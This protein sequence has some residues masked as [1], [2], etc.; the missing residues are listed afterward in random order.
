MLQAIQETRDADLASHRRLLS[1]DFLHFLDAEDQ[2]RI[3]EMLRHEIGVA[4]KGRAKESW[5]LYRQLEPLRYN[6]PLRSDADRGFVY[7]VFAKY[8]ARLE[9]SGHFDTDDIVLT[10]HNQLDTPIWRRRRIRE[11][12]DS[13]FID[14]THLFNINELMLFHHLTRAEDRHPVVL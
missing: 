9:R 13:L 14:E 2:W 10:A 11:G 5:E 1:S 6:L 4:I 3:A 7:A 8:K 12:Y